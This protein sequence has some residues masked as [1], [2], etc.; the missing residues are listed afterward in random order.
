LLRGARYPGVGHLLFGRVVAATSEPHMANTFRRIGTLALGLVLAA[1]CA[2][3]RTTAPAAITTPGAA[4]P[5]LVGG[6]VGTVTST[7]GLT[8][9][10]GVLRTTPLAA[11]ITVTKT[12]GRDGGI[13][14][15]PAAG[16]TVTVPSGA[17]SASTVITMTARKGSLIAYDFAPH[18]ITFARPLIFKQS[19]KGTNAALLDGPF[20]RLSYYTDP[21]L[22]GS[23][24]VKVSELI[25]GV[26]NV[27]DWSF[28]AP[29][30]HFSGYI[31]TCGRGDAGE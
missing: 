9:T 18:G 15:I 29:I 6:L 11:N 16:V 14:T 30:T 20:L 5:D 10:N 23:V 12:I 24:T 13:L 7:L 19:L 27:L 26:L 3:D 21:S 8:T 1:G 31:M 22:L 28:T 25:V 2:Q 4:S 17:L